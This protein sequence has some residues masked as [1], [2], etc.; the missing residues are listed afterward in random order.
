MS[1]IFEAQSNLTSAIVEPILHTRQQTRFRRK[2]VFQVKR[3]KERHSRKSH[4]VK[5]T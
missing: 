5:S 2:H 1:P 4:L 3:S